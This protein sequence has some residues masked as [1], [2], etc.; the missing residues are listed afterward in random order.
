M[1]SASKLIPASPTRFSPPIGACRP[2]QFLALPA[3]SKYHRLF[4]ILG[5]GAHEGK[6]NILFSDGHV[7]ESRDAIVPPEETVA[8]DLVYPDVKATDGFSPAGGIGGAGGQNN[9][10]F[11]SAKVAGSPSQPVSASRELPNKVSAANSST[12]PDYSINKNQPARPKPMVF[13]GMGVPENFSNATLVADAPQTSSAAVVQ[14]SA[15][16]VVATNED[17]GMSVFDRRIV[18]TLRNVFGWGYLLLLLL[19]LLWLWFKLRREWRRQEQRQ[20]R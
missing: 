20:K 7:E 11:P 9:F 2:V 3:S 4:H 8:E 6:G 14:T 15:N 19:F 13:N 1:S 12:R 17:S 5:Q 16:T 18:K 10:S